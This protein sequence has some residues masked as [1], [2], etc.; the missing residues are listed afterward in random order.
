[1]K[2]TNGKRSFQFIP[3]QVIVDPP[4]GYP[5]LTREQSLA[6]LLY[7]CRRL[8]V[9]KQRTKTKH[10][11][12][13]WLIPGGGIGHNHWPA[14]SPARDFSYERL[15]YI[16]A[17]LAFPDSPFLRFA[18]ASLGYRSLDKPI[19]IR[20]HTS[21][22]FDSDIDWLSHLQGIRLKTSPNS[23]HKGAVWL[24]GAVLVPNEQATR[25]GIRIT[26]SYRHEDSSWS[27][28]LN[29]KSGETF[30]AFLDR[31]WQWLEPQIQWRHSEEWYTRFLCGVDDMKK[32]ELKTC[33]EP[34]SRMHRLKKSIEHLF[35]K[36]K[37]CPPYFENEI[38]ESLLTEPD[39]QYR[40]LD[41]IQLTGQRLSTLKQWIK[42]DRKHRTQKTP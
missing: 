8:R 3:A 33:S 13:D 34:E 36:A 19:T 31:A 24:H 37:H 32:N 9:W 16:L 39:P 28:G 29:Q 23:Y 20:Q 27:I 11:I 18:R 38:A 10:N 26:Y 22:L 17:K 21:R 15:Q 42:Q 25:W 30:R 4:Y 40:S 41:R 12:Y 6:A 7:I 14:S 5:V 35:A 1:M 2:R